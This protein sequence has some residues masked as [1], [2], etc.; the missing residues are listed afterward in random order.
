MKN[1]EPV[2]VFIQTLHPDGYGLS[3]GEDIAVFG[4]LAGETV[5]AKP[6]TR[7]RRR[8]FARAESII[9]SS[10][11][12]VPPVCS[13][14]GVCGGCSLQ[15]MDGQYQIGFKQNQLLEL[16]ASNQP[17]E[18]IEPITGPITNYRGK[19]RLGARYVR[20]MDR[21]LVGFREKMSPLIALI[22]RCHV[23]QDPVGA[24]IPELARLIEGLS[25]SGAIPQIEV[26]AG[27]DD[28]ALVFRHMV[29]LT[30][31]DQGRLIE[32]GENHGLAIYLQPGDH[33][34]T[35]KIHPADSRERLIYSLPDYGLKMLFHPLDFV[36]V[37]PEINKKLVNAALSL[38]QLGGGDR[39]LDSF[40][41]I[42]NFTLP[43]ATR[44]A[45]AYGLEGSATSVTRAR[46]NAEYNKIDNCAFDVADLL[47]EGLDIPALN[48]VNKVLL[49]PPRTGA[50]HLV[51]KLASSKVERV[52]YV[53]C[54]PR[55][56]ARDAEMLVRSGY[57]FEKAGVIDM[58]PH[59][60]HIES[61]ALF[62]R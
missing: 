5:I 18:L 59:T 21:V 4:A 13:A 14:A 31:D 56:L 29:D 38:L 60:T 58:F 28:V 6:F 22:D 40:C 49:D 25:C 51:K 37:N 34:S 3:A 41:G 15:H 20:K 7:K 62:S 39:V 17:D 54:N 53:S 12:R 47:D 44:T 16:L 10:R 19:A 50:E 36:Q 1:R 11:E 26:A 52:V 2:E 46:E 27:D 9:S 8:T 61:M 33:A 57:R 30:E 45:F 48:E 23:L 55:T 24:L 43:L 32:F 35:Y 42:G